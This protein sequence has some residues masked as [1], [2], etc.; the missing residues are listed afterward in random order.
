M[1][2][3]LANYERP[4]RSLDQLFQAVC[5]QR[6]VLLTGESGTGKSTLLTYCQSR[7]TAISTTVPIQLRNSCVGVAEI[8]DRIGDSVGWERLPRFGRRIA[9]VD[10]VAN[11]K[12][13]HNRLY[14]MNNKITFV[15]SAE[16]KTDRDQR[17]GTLSSELFSDLGSHDNLL[18]LLF[19]TFEQ[20][21]SEVQD[22]LI[23]PFLARASRARNV[24]V[25]IAGRAVPDPANIEWG[26]C[27]ILHK[28]IGVTE[29]DHWLPLIEEMGYS[30]P[31]T[32][33]RGFVECM[34]DILKGH[35]H[36]IMQYINGFPRR[37]I[38]Q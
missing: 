26:H 29:P 31:G 38:S 11:P 18:V 5:D 14:G 22:W 9:A 23:G 1:T 12:I 21:P 19:D 25:A 10:G 32:Q 30:V 17:L 7:A 24:R 4:R 3:K 28:L 6:I 8:L 20:A 15:L 13:D 36:S 37:Q 16:T 35:P 33:P 27:S 34:C 2:V